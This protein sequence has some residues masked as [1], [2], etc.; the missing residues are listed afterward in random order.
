[1]SDAQ[2]TARLLWQYGEPIHAVMFFAPETQAATD[3]LGLKGGWMS[4][5]GCRAAPLGEVTTEVV[6]SIFYGFN[7]RVVERAI[8]DAWS[9]AS[10]TA[11]LEARLSAMDLALRRL[12]DDEI[13][14]DATRRAAALAMAIVDE[15]DFSGLALGAT[16]AALAWPD[17]PHLQL[18][19]ALGAIREGRGDG[20]VACLVAEQIG[21]C[22]SLVLQGAT[23]RSDADAL[24]SRR[25]WSVE[26][27]RDALDR[28]TGRG[29]VDGD[30]HITN[31]GDRARELIE[32]MTDRVAAST[33]PIDDRASELVD[34]M[35]PLAERIMAA[36][37]VP[38]QN[39][40]GLPWPP[41]A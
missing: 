14:S 39:N 26:E 29:M 25:G 18:W 28:L 38:Q 36:G 22:E 13:D 16:N 17:A 5:F 10:P 34:V 27:W 21:P 15:G 33:I 32:M 23:G 1:M 30:G 41:T 24:R 40:M 31:A 9:Y 19:Q 12:L 8:P 2:R 11:L 7:R 20:H 6:T 3:A 35:R 4:Y 37:E